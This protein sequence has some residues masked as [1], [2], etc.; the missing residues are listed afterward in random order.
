MEGEFRVRPPGELAEDEDAQRLLAGQA[1][2]AGVGIAR[3][4]GVEVLLNERRERRLLV[5]Q[6]THRR[7]FG[8][9]RVIDP[10]R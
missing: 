2:A 4:A 3:T 5:Q 10:G 1:G 8:R 7:Q 6:R 9:V